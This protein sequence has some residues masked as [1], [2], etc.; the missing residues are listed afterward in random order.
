MCFARLNVA[1]ADDGAHVAHN[2]LVEANNLVG[3]HVDLNGVVGADAGV[4]KAD[5]ARVGG[6]GDGDALGANLNALHLAKR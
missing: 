2:E 4:G 5:G 1:P 6:V 3:L